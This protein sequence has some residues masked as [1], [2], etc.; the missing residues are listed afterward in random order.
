MQEL[1]KYLTPCSII[2]RLEFSLAKKENNEI[3]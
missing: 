2:S 1:H 3:C